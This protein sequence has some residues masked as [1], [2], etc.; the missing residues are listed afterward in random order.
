MT[1]RASELQPRET[2]S[3]GLA[4]GLAGATLRRVIA[5]TAAAA[6]AIA[7]AG[8]S[9]PLPVNTGPF[10]GAGNSG[11]NCVPISHPGELVTEGIN[12]VTDSWRGTVA[13]ITKISLVRPRGLRL[14]RAYAMRL[15]NHPSY[16]DIPGLPPYAGG[17]QKYPWK[18]HVNA[19]G[20]RVPYTRNTGILTNL[21]L[22][23]KTSARKSTD[24]GIHV[25]YRVGTQQYQ[26]RTRFGLELL[27]SPARC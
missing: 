24:Q 8:C 18:G 6:L 13:I 11:Q 17:L 1:R 26:L 25:W 5:A 22:V 14:L 15:D 23:L 16:G 2:G 3:R 27:A 10:G 21:L 12:E 7:A 4:P 9:G 19:V 20:A